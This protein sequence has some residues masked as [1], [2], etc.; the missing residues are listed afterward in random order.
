VIHLKDVTVTYPL[1]Y[2]GILVYLSSA[3]G[4]VL[5]GTRTPDQLIRSEWLYPSELPRQQDNRRLSIGLEGIEPSSHRY[6][7]WALTNRRQ[8]H[9]P[10]GLCIVERHRRGGSY[11]RV[12]TSPAH[13]SIIGSLTQLV[14][15]LLPYERSSLQKSPT[16]V[17]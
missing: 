1:S 6:K 12:G 9:R 10:P 3:S 16:Y 17:P 2:H 8:S 4:N 13:E 15:P 11:R 7:Q 14:K 5:G